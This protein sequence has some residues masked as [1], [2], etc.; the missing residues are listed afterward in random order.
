MER[1]LLCIFAEKES[2]QNY[3][4]LLSIL[5]D[6]KEPLWAFCVLPKMWTPTHPHTGSNVS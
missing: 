5:H 6:R 1:V 4:R 2:V 3:T